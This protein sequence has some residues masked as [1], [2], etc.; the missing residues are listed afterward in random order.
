MHRDGEL[1]ASVPYRKRF[2]SLD[3]IGDAMPLK[4]FDSLMK[5]RLSQPEIEEIE[6]NALSTYEQ[7]VQSLTPEEQERFSKKRAKFLRNAKHKL[8]VK[9]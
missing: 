3:V 7:F 4:S 1:C 8:I 6:N 2:Y 5:Q 9:L